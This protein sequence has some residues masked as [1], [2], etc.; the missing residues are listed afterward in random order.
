MFYSCFAVG[1]DLSLMQIEWKRQAGS[2]IC[3]IGRA[4]SCD[5][6]RQE[7]HTALTFCKY[8][9]PR[10]N[11]M[12]YYIAS[13][14]TYVNALV[15]DYLQQDYRGLEALGHSC[16]QAIWSNL[17]LGRIIKQ[18]QM[19]RNVSF[20]IANSADDC[21]LHYTCITNFPQQK[22]KGAEKVTDFFHKS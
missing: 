3:S 5:P 14:K 22:D 8:A 15:N 19:K 7:I 18:Y 9:F 2:R 4:R 6:Y 10:E 1:F 21:E 16:K 12:N 20:N 11:V 17:G 13:N